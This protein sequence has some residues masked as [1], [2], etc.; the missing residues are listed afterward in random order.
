MRVDCWLD[1]FLVWVTVIN[2]VCC[3]YGQLGLFLLLAGVWSVMVVD[4]GCGVGDLICQWLVGFVL[5]DLWIFWVPT[6][7]FLGSGF[8][9]WDLW[10]LW[11]LC[12]FACLVAKKMQVKKKKSWFFFLFFRQPNMIFGER[13]WIVKRKN[14]KTWS[15]TCSSKTIMKRRNFFN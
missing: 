15:P 14:V 9:L 11:E 3:W 7:V 10:A 4:G 2:W 13:T 5:W 1:L 8:V 12:V 6:F